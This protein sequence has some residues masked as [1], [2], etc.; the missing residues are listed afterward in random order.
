MLYLFFYYFLYSD[1]YIMPPLAAGFFND[2]ISRQ[3]LEL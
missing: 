2:L 1:P 3:F